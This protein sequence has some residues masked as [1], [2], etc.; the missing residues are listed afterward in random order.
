MTTS[1]AEKNWRSR[2]TSCAWLVCAVFL[3]AAVWVTP[4]NAQGTTPQAAAPQATEPPPLTSAQLEQL[5]APIALYPDD[6]LSQVLMAS[7]YPLEVVQAARWVAQNPSVSGK[8]L[9]DA[10]AKQP[11]DSS[12]K[13]L[14]AV[15]QTLQM[16]SDKL[17]WTQQLGDA[18]LDDQGAVLDAVQRLRKRA[19][20]TGN[21]KTSSQMK[22][23]NVSKP[24]PTGQPVER[25]VVEPVDPEVMYVPVYDPG[26]AFGTWPYP[27]YP[28]YYWQPP[29]WI[30]GTFAYGAVA[31]GASVAV[32]AA[33]WGGANWW[34]RSVN[35]NANRYNSFNR[36]NIANGNWNHNGAHR[37]NVPY[38]N[39]AAAQK[40]GGQS[41]GNRAGNRQ[42]AGGAGGAGN[43]QGLGGQG[44]GAG[45]RGAGNRGAGAGQKGAGA[46]QKGAGNRQGGAGAKGGGQGAHKGGGHKAAGGGGGNRAGNIGG[47][48]GMHRAGGG[49]GG[50]HRAGGMGG[51]RMGG[52]HGGGMRMGGGGG[53]RMGGGGGRGGGGGGRG[54]RSDIT[55]K[56]DIVYLGHLD[57][58]LGF[59][60]FSYSGSDKAYVGVMAQ[61]VQFVRPDAVSRDAE[62]ILRVHYDRLGVRFQTYDQWLHAGARVPASV[63]AH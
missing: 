54:R 22:V 52:G 50:M 8:A 38:R 17:D 19:E 14:A 10:M 9:E 34:N 32:G 31:F 29:G 43:R 13:G 35:I 12:V 3:A 23:S 25:I 63:R 18:F 20:G 36:T 15:P 57:N 28:P 21:L 7:T 33:I 42:G 53:A 56:H 60:R 2:L 58:G 1:I 24:G 59:Y 30:P 11:W 5:V 27:D 41:A 61:E 26:V 49:A 47:G 62:G 45:Q 37:G 6:L 4:V 39:N 40:F 48:G 16:M 46:G 44:G 55:V 51:A